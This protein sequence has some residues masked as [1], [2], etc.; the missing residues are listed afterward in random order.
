MLLE[1]F[2]LLFRG[3]FEFQ[4]FIQGL[5]E[6]GQLSIRKAGG[7]RRPPSFLAAGTDRPAPS[8][9]SIQREA[10]QPNARGRL[11]LKVIRHR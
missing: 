5:G 6:S 7:A 11:S 10:R 9:S 2:H 1:I 4:N 3:I 8:S